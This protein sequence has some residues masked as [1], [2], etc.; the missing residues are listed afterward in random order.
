MDYIVCYGEGKFDDIDD[1]N[2]EE[3]EEK[4][5]AIS[6]DCNDWHLDFLMYQD[7]IEQGRG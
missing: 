6:R 4:Y 5:V 3:A 7:M 1:D 2:D